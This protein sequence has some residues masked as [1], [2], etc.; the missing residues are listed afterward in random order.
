VNNKSRESKSKEKKMTPQDLMSSYLF[1]N[2]TKGK[3]TTI[4][5]NKLAK[6]ITNPTSNKKPDKMTIN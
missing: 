6:F 4:S 5:P 1:K 3:A 2:A